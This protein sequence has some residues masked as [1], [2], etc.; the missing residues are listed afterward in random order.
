MKNI[1]TTVEHSESKNAW[2]VVGTIPGLKYKIA[3]C[4]YIVVPES[5]ILTTLNKNEALEHA[6]FI[7]KAFNEKGVN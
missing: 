3:R 2:N 7:S 6:L 5:E 1:K 4:P